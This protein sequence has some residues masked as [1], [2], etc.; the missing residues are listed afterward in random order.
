MSTGIDITKKDIAWSYISK[1]FQIGSGLITLPLILHMLT[2]EEVGMN[3]LML[4]VGS[5]VSLFDFGFSPQF[6]RNITYCYSGATKLCKTGVDNIETGEVNY[7][8]LAT[9]IKTAKF[10]YH[11]LSVIVL[12]GMLTLGSYYIGYITNGFKNVNNSLIIWI[13]YSIS[14]YFNMY[15]SYYTSLL[16][17][18]GMINESCKAEMLNRIGYLCICVV[19]LLLGLG[20]FSIV[21]A[22]L[23]APF[24][25]RYYCYKVYYTERLKK[26]M[27][28]EIDKN[29]IKQTYDVI[30][31]NAKR[32]GVN[33]LGSYAINKFAMFLIGFYLSLNII[34]SYGLLIQLTTV[35][36]A[37]ATTLFTTYIPKFSSF[38][39]TNDIKGLKDYFSFSMLI[40]WV[41]MILGS[42]IIIIWGTPILYLLK[43]KTNLP[44]AELCSMYLMIALLEGN[45]SLSATLITTDNKVP[46]VKPSLISG[47][48]IIILSFLSLRFTNLGLKGV[49]LVQGIVQLAYNNWK[50]PIWVYKNLNYSSKEFMLLGVQKIVRDIKNKL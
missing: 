6:G 30:W 17:G 28:F 47:G 9:V 5:I 14:T 49:I 43:S 4:T 36:T 15:F 13:V 25:Q 26:K 40:Y 24:I 39:V 45:H 38:R 27:N 21:I 48:A 10:V 3:Y 33:F 16:T 1:F 50:W 32:L 8:L 23:I 35:L 19:L 11:R 2:P 20:L 41:L 42:C 46:F 18:S 22:N 44:N 34:A 29:E 37:I 31:Y 7:R 12:I